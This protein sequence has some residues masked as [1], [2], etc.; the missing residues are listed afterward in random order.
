[1]EN[2][3][4][5]VTGASRGIGRGIAVELTKGGYRVMINFVR[6]ATAAAETEDLVRQAGGTG[7]TVQGDVSLASDRQRLVAETLAK[8]GRIDLL[9]NN[10]GVGP[11][12]RTDLL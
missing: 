10:A 5:L 6:N 3:A 11:A 2:R 7:F 12:T 9:V 8:F 1:M 4:A